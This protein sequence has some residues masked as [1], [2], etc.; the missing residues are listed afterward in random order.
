VNV[1]ESGSPKALTT[2]KCKWFLLVM[3]YENPPQ[4]LSSRPEKMP[5]E[6]EEA[7]Y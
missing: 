2:A 1:G 4:K 3:I 7:G 5:R 6:Y